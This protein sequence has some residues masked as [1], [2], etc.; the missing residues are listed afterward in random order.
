M[1]NQAVKRQ[2]ASPTVAAVAGATPSAASAPVCAKCKDTGRV[3]FV[4]PK[5]GLRS[6]GPCECV[7]A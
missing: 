1:A 7:K 5:R 2:G 6:V 4:E 3:I